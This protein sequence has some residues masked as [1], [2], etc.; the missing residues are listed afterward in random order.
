M[1]PKELKQKVDHL[2]TLRDEQGALLTQL[3]ESSCLQFMWPDVWKFGKIKARWEGNVMH[4][5]ERCRFI[6]ERSD[7]VSRTWLLPEVPGAIRDRF[8]NERLKDDEFNYRPADAKR[9]R[10]LKAEE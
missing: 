6:V 7:G 4:H 9:L 1:N 8:I 5:P 10:A 2:H 3:Q